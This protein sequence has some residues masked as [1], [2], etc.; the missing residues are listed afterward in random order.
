MSGYITLLTVPI[1]MTLVTVGFLA[2]MYFNLLTVTDNRTNQDATKDAVVA[3]YSWLLS[4][5]ESINSG[6]AF[7]GSLDSTQCG[8]GKWLGGLSAEDLENP[9]I[10]EAVQHLKAP[11]DYIHSQAL[12]ILDKAA[13]NHDNAYATYL[14]EIKPRVT[15]IIADIT[16]VTNEYGRMSAA[17]Y[18]QLQKNIAQL[19]I[20]CVLLIAVGLVFSIVLGRKTAKRISYPVQRVAEWS[21]ELALGKDDVDTNEIDL[22]GIP[23]E[24]EVHVMTKA[25][26]E[27]ALGLQNN[28]KVIKRVAEGDLTA[29][30]DIRSKEDTL[31][32][33]I[34]RMVQSNDL[35][36]ASILEVSGDVAANANQISTASDALAASA[37]EQ[38]ASVTQLSESIKHV[39]RLA[40]DNVSKV[41]VVLDNFE[42]IQT[43]VRSSTDQMEQLV[44]AVEEIRL[45]SDRVSSVIKSI[46]DIAFQTNI[47]ALNAAIE[48]ARAGTAGKGFAVVADEVRQLALKSSTAADESKVIIQSTIE[49]SYEGTKMAKRTHENFGKIANEIINTSG[50]IDA[51][52]EASRQQETEIGSVYENITSIAAIAESNA[53]SCEES[54]AASSEMQQSASI[55]KQQMSKFTLRQREFGKPYIPVE[56]QN[57]EQFIAEANANYQQML[58]KMDRNDKV[59]AEIAAKK[60]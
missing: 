35:M 23:P 2:M 38:A 25:F 59:F 53:A 51:I 43:D 58:A 21:K 36:F 31:G 3:H 29:F 56:K 20:I 54:S 12:S 44:T 37:T 42:G 41:H 19:I 48:A 26:K 16:V 57:D 40:T 1:L 52:S 27:M 49:K 7:T 15:E 33:N 24:N 28:V 55:L 18:T 5:E 30:V 39:S 8:L 10:A 14:K 17:G 4:L 9:V 6:A 22:S 32:Q 45:A 34:Y 13:I 11:H 47:L 50:V 46:E 60:Y